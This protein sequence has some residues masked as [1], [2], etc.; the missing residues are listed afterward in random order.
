MSK[1]TSTCCCCLLFCRCDW[2]MAAASRLAVSDYVSDATKPASHCSS[3]C[4][5]GTKGTAGE[6][7][8]VGRQLEGPFPAAQLNC[9]AAACS[10][11]SALPAVVSLQPRAASVLACRGCMYSLTRRQHQAQPRALSQHCGNTPS[12]AG[13]MAA[14]VW[15]RALSSKPLTSL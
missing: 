2:P 5:L 10:C 15:Q 13:H 4:I 6:A 14:P 1:P 8:A 3:V 7:S 11:A 12:P 9:C